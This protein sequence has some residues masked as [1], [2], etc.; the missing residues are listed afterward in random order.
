MQKKIAL[1]NEKEDFIISISD[2]SF[3]DTRNEV[4][5]CQSNVRRKWI[6]LPI[7]PIILS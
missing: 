4:T 5:T 7:Q 6:S 1:T 3:I 2:I